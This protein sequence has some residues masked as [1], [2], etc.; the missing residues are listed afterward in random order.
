M[1]ST[2]T[3]GGW[4]PAVLVAL[5]E[6]AGLAVTAALEDRMN[7]NYAKRRLA[8]ELREHWFATGRHRHRPE[9][10]LLAAI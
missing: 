5:E 1:T 8:K 7:F 2:D 3:G 10:L 6:A 4:D 9:A